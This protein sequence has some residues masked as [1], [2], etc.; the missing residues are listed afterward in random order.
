MNK[1]LEEKANKLLKSLYKSVKKVSKKNAI[2]DVLD[3]NNV[4]EMS[5]DSEP[6]DTAGV[7]AKNKDKK[8]K[9]ECDC[10]SCAC[11]SPD[12]EVDIQKG[13]KFIGNIMENFKMISELYLEKKEM[14][15]K[16]RM[17][18]NQE[19]QPVRDKKQSNKLH[20]KWNKENKAY[21]AHQEKIKDTKLDTDHPIIGGKEKTREKNIPES[22][23]KETKASYPKMAASE[24]VK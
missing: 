13:E 19:M 22:G 2:D 14:L 16:N 9:K 12:E 10:D 1:E 24:K 6:A 18:T 11:A 7:M 23:T 8:D 20:S 15:E 5:P 4:A 21:Q 17:A 3:S